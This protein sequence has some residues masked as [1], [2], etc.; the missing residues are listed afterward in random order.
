M[1]NR[2]KTELPVDRWA[3]PVDRCWATE[4][5]FWN[6]WF[7]STAQGFPVDQGISGRPLERYRLT[8]AGKTE[9][10]FCKCIT[11]WPLSRPHHFRSTARRFRSTAGFLIRKNICLRSTAPEI[12]VDRRVSV[13]E[14]QD[15][16][17]SISF[18]M[19]I[20]VR[21]MLGEHL[22]TTLRCFLAWTWPNFRISHIYIVSWSPKDRQTEER[23][24]TSAPQDL[25][26]GSC[27]TRRRQVLLGPW[28]LAKRGWT[29]KLHGTS[30]MM[31]EWR[32][33]RLRSSVNTN[34]NRDSSKLVLESFVCVFSFEFWSSDCLS[35]WGLIKNSKRVCVLD[36]CV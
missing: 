34:H 8:A 36:R 30:S 13:F 21:G 5:K 27:C 3:V 18:H 20:Q 1:K 24:K 12:P 17:E 14:F 15:R 23:H 2:G 7:R 9:S 35:V 26:V 6:C 10:S 29:S 11:G 19:L 32:E 31:R 25:D 4:L 28:K 16:S 22:W 33:L